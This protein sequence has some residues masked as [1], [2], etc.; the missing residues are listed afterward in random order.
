VRH[1]PASQ[2]E[3]YRRLKQEILEREKL[4]LQ[5]K[6]ANNNNSSSSN[7]KLSNA[8]VASSSVKSLPACE[9][10]AHVKQNQDKLKTPERNLQESSIEVGKKNNIARGTSELNMCH[11]SADK[12]LSTNIAKHTKFTHL[13]AKSSK[14][15]IPNDLS[16][17]ITNVTAPSHISDRTVENSRENQ[18]AKDKQQH[19]PALRTLSKDEINRKYVQVLSNSD[20]IDRVVI[21]NDKSVLQHDTTINVDQ[22]E[23]LI[24]SIEMTDVNREILNEKNLNDD[25]NTSSFS[26][27][28]TV[29]LPKLSANLCRHEDTM[30]TTMTLS[31]YET[32]CQQEICRDASTSILANNNDS[33]GS[34]KSDTVVDENDNANDVWDA[35]KKDV[36]A[37]LDSLTSLPE[38]EQERYLRETEHKLVARR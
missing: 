28:S 36:K 25:I 17:R 12:K 22:S 35:L 16:I 15:A 10:K 31:E 18:S 19:R 24:K 20:T 4:K 9:K 6:V 3:E 1:L 23:N 33:N 21:I 29:K 7:N 14:R 8:N 32:E 11:M 34:H 26:N 27:A 13:Q 37:E 2:Q 38:V 5:R 30:E